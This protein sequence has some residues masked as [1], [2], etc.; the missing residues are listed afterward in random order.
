MT[1][2]L[3]KYQPVKQR[4]DL[5]I[6]DHP[7]GVVLPI[8]LS[9]PTNIGQE[10]GYIVPVFYKQTDLKAGADR[11]ATVVKQCGN[12]DL[13]L[14]I[15]IMAPDGI[16]TAYENKNMTGASKTSWTEN[17]EE[18][19]IGR[20]LDNVGYHGDGKCSREEILKVQ[21]VESLTEENP[22][23]PGDLPN[24]AGNLPP[25]GTKGI[26]AARAIT[27]HAETLGWSEEKLA[28]WLKARHC[29]DLGKVKAAQAKALLAAIKDEK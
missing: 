6:K 27:G 16:G 11:L 28:K 10:A 23:E 4:K 13:R 18:S 15:L 8:L 29:D 5:F 25:A 2:D 9:D 1:F 3:S 22:F 17:A 24:H 7:Y 19:A 26:N 14:A 20:A 21:E 12:I